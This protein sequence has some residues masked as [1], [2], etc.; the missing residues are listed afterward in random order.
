MK[1]FMG[2][3]EYLSIQKQYVTFFSWQVFF[4]DQISKEIPNIMEI[5]EFK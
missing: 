4:C 2:S 1:F 5:D 3:E